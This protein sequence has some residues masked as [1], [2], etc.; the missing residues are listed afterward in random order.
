LTSL[1]LALRALWWRRGL[2]AAV[3]A[4]AA[5]V[6]AVAVAGPTYDR[7]AK[8]SILQ[9]VLRAAPSQQSGLELTEGADPSVLLGTVQSALN[10]N[11][12]QG[13]YRPAILAREHLFHGQIG[14]AP[15]GGVPVLGRLVWRDGAEDHLRLRAGRLPRQA[16]EVLATPGFLVY[17]HGRLGQQLTLPSG[18]PERIVGAYTASADD[19]YWF[20]RPYFAA[21]ISPP[22]NRDDPPPADALLTVRAGVVNGTGVVDLPLR[23]GGVRVAGAAET[24]KRQQAVITELGASTTI[25]QADGITAATSLSQLLSTAS[26]N[27]HALGAPVLLIVLQLLLLCALV[28]F[29]AVRAAAEARGPEV[30]LLKLRGA[31]PSKLLVFGLAEPLFLITAALPVGV[32]LGVLAVHVM[33]AIQFVG[34]TPITLGLPALLAGLAAVAGAAVATAGSGIRIVRRPVTEQ[35]RRANRRPG[36]R[37]NV[38]A[39][40][41]CV[42]AVLALAAVIRRAGLGR[43]D[44]AGSVPD[45]TTLAV[46]ALLSVVVAVVA[47]SVLPAACRA[48]FVPNRPGARRPGRRGAG[49]RLG[50]FLAVRQIARRPASL[51]VVVVLVLAFGLASFAF[52]AHRVALGNR[53]DVA[54]ATVGASRVLTV[55]V[56]RDADLGS[57]VDR[58][59]PTGRQAMAVIDAQQQNGS[60]RDLL[61]VQPARF[62][63]VAAWRSDYAPAP[64]RRVAAA[65]T[66]PGLNVVSLR[67]TA[68]RM[69]VHV[70]V[71]TGASQVTPVLSVLAPD[72]MHSAKG[73]PLPATGTAEL[74]WP[75]PACALGCELASLTLQRADLFGLTDLAGEITVGNLAVQDS[76]GWREVPAGLGQA[77]GWVG[78]R[79]PGGAYFSRIGPPSRIDASSGDRVSG[80]QLTYTFRL[81]H[82]LP[83]TLSPRSLPPQL[84]VVATS[85]ASVDA[86]PGGEAPQIIGLDGQQQAVDPRL[87]ADVLPRAGRVGVL[88]DRAL[89]LRAAQDRPVDSIQQVWLAPGASPQIQTAL[90]AAGVQVAQT[91]SAQ[92]VAAGLAQQGPPLA[93]LLFV[94]GA[95][96]AALLA[97]AGAALSLTLAARR[98][99]FELAA[100]QALGIGRAALLRSVLVE[101]LA[102]LGL[103]VSLG[104]GSGLV[105]ASFALS[106][107]PEF[108]DPPLAPDLLYTPPY[109]PVLGLTTL[110]GGI[111][112]VAVTLSCAALV[113]RVRPEMLREAAP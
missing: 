39:G 61:G 93:L 5:I 57:L 102:L 27:E 23:P 25:T 36:W 24:G 108:T 71:L 98:R 100:L 69:R 49:R 26:A 37:R 77:N 84:P 87:G 32:V 17:I 1:A 50:G 101:Q 74:S 66:V 99:G 29:G 48:L 45:A 4:V 51:G 53:H 33:G 73:T 68:V 109:L 28:L 63:A 34:G 91:Q 83:P 55:D 107:V 8:E 12:L 42:A 10:D 46:P 85:G 92:Q 78:G 104:L 38:A 35:W 80:P 47:A 2:S 54:A 97:L 70:N 13:L 76:G 43:S 44:A 94:V 6:V 14:D 90:E 64:A 113:R 60:H 86:S 52:S 41:S 106:G 67:S 75:T 31:P 79:S 58:A 56:P 15:G 88:V 72:G 81:P 7:A 30:A 9:Y 20:A 82:E 62:P 18:E 105:S 96:V 59:D 22:K 40:L 110:L 11:H 16:G 3:A 112:A 65:L 21:L 95:G 111:V 103:G 89:A 19:P